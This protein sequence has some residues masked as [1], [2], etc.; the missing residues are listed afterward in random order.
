MADECD[1]CHVRVAASAPDEAGAPHGERFG[2]TEIVVI[3]YTESSWGVFRYTTLML[4]ESARISFGLG[5][6]CA[7]ELASNR[8]VPCRLGAAKAGGMTQR[9]TTFADDRVVHLRQSQPSQSR[10][11]RVPSI[12]DEAGV[13]VS[14]SY[15]DKYCGNYFPSSAD[16]LLA[17]NSSS[18]QQ[19]CC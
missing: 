9:P 3:V 1:A 15:V 18:L 11:S 16:G 12:A 19:R 13:H 17:A 5:V 6:I 7:W 2:A 8:I 4:A 10:F 14:E